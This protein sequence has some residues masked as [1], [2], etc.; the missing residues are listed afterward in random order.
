[1]INQSYNKA[2]EK[3]LTDNKES[4]LNDWIELAKMPSQELHHILKGKASVR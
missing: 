1:M 4:I 2:L 3:W